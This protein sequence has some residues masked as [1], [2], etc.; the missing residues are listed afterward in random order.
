M[1]TFEKKCLFLNLKKKKNNRINESSTL[2]KSP[3]TRTQRAAIIL[4]IHSLAI[5]KRLNLSTDHVHHNPHVSDC[6]PT[7]GVYYTCQRVYYNRS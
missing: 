6:I 7:R 4:N 5:K 1:L 3:C 2:E